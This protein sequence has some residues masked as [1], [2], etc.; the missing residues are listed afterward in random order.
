MIAYAGDWQRGGEL[1]RK[2]RDCISFIRAGIGSSLLDL[3]HG[4]YSAALE[5]PTE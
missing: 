3:S 1:S 2:A 4:D 5:L